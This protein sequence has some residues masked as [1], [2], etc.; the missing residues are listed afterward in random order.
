MVAMKRAVKVRVEL[1]A[2]LRKKF[3]KMVEVEC[4]GTIEDCFIQA[5]KVLGKDFLKEVMKNGKL[6]DDRIITVNGRNIKDELRRL[7]DGDVVS[8]FPPIAGGT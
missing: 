3:G 2:T 1:F 7:E 8:V 5:S 6:R 4:N